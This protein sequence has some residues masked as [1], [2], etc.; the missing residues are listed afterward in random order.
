MSDR[1]LN[2]M[3]STTMLR[4][5]YWGCGGG[6]MECFSGA[7][8]AAKPFDNPHPSCAKGAASRQDGLK[9]TPS[10]TAWR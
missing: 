4:E 10:K 2:C 1:K 9:A 5:L 7:V 6:V 3:S 8:V